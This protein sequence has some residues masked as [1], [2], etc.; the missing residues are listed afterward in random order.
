M[1]IPAG[2][3]DHFSSDDANCHS[4]VG[5]LYWFMYVCFV[6]VIYRIHCV[7]IYVYIRNMWRLK[8]SIY[9]IVGNCCAISSQ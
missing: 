3:C 5:Q 8:C 9:L 1:G 6:N 4:V 7:N 2:Y